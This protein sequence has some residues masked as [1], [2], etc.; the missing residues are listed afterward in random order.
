M[1]ETCLSHQNVLEGVHLCV[2]LKELE[3]TYVNGRLSGGHVAKKYFSPAEYAH[4]VEHVKYR[5][6]MC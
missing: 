2:Y 5:L 6:L 4:N 3:F 1:Q